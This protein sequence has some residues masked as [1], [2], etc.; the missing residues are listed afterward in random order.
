MPFFSRWCA[1][2]EQYCGKRGATKCQ[3]IPHKFSLHWGP[4]ICLFWWGIRSCTCF[5]L[6]AS[7]LWHRFDTIE[8]YFKH[9]VSSNLHKVPHFLCFALQYLQLI[10]LKYFYNDCVY[11]K[12]D[13]SCVTPCKKR[14]TL[15]GKK[16]GLPLNSISTC[17]TLDNTNCNLVFD[18]SD[19]KYFID[20]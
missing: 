19:K 17:A 5:R 15:R 8:P 2:V 6:E 20:F 14:S 4:I 13:K 9:I 12:K 16:C 11:L 18:M 10:S 3:D 7:H 1:S